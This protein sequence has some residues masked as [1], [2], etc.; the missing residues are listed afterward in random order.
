MSNKPV[1]SAASSRAKR[2]RPIDPH[3]VRRA[4]KLAAGYEIRVEPNSRGYVGTVAD[5]PTVFGVGPSEAAALADAR[6][7]LAWAL[8]YLLDSGRTLPLKR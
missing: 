3:V 1:K 2:D 6:R 4:L 7:H 8:A 5:L